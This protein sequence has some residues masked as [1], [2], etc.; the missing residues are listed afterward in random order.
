MYEYRKEMNAR[1]RYFPWQDSEGSDTDILEKFV[2]VCV[3]A[4]A[5]TRPN[6]RQTPC[7][8]LSPLPQTG[9]HHLCF[10]QAS[11]MEANLSW[12]LLFAVE[13][14]WRILIR[15]KLYPLFLLHRWDWILWL[16]EE[17]QRHE[18]FQLNGTK[19]TFFFFAVATTQYCT[20]SRS[21]GSSK[22]M[23]LLWFC[24]HGIMSG[25]VGNYFP[26]SQ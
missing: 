25:F 4:P 15:G 20:N 26:A 14:C 9:Q 24:I 23:K 8:F 5:R 17:Q 21:V 12:I 18:H 22:G 1:P 7:D 10:W 19:T 11:F 3:A 13:F 6:Y 16:E 2:V